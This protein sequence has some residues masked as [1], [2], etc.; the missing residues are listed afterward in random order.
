MNAGALLALL[1]GLPACQDDLPTAL[2]PAQTPGFVTLE[3]RLEPAEHLEDIGVFRGFADPRAAPYLLVAREFDG[4][5]SAHA[6]AR[7]SAL[8]DS[9]RYSSGGALITD[10]AYTVLGGELKT[11][12]DTLSFPTGS[13]VTLEAWSIAQDWDPSSVTWTHAV[14]TAGAREAWATP[15]GT[16]GE[17]LGSVEWPQGA[18]GSDSLTMELDWSKLEALLE[19][20][21]TPDILVT[22]VGAGSRI[23]LGRIDL[24]VRVQPETTDTI[25]D[26][27]A[28][29]EAQRF[30]TSSTLTLHP[31]QVGGVTGDRH[32]F[33]LKLPPLLACPSCPAG[34]I[35]S[36][37]VMLARAELIF[38]SQA[39]PGGFRP[40]RSLQVV[41]R[42]LGDPPRGA[43][44]EVRWDLAPLGSELAGAQFEPSRFE[45][46]GEGP[47]TM[48]ITGI[49][50]EMQ[51][52]DLPIN[53]AA[54][55]EPS[56]STFGFARLA[57]PRLRLIYTIP[58]Q[59]EL[60]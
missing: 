30:I 33:R 28:P 25:I 55:V 51:L 48:V 2:D 27:T 43:G 56:G 12:V 58:Q 24:V 23:Q 4:A 60:P 26:I 18:A 19:D 36:N 3:E 15:G 40:M 8:P 46:G 7:F 29:V 22:A 49:V 20:F 57:P 54:M 34:T 1:V 5:L 41:L 31:W 16:R 47:V 35:R 6:L 37:Q 17:L 44:D 13:S 53:V 32:L 42:R 14:D 21:S 11:V 38:D 9:I 50:R 45:A 39:V 59:P 52:R 10:T